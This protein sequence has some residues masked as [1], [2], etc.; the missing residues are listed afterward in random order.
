MSLPLGAA[1]AGAVGVVRMTRR[2]HAEKGGD[3]ACVLV[4]RGAGRV[5]MRGAT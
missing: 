2:L 3:G 1:S 4:V 5:G